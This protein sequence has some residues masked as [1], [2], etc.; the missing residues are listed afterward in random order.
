AAQEWD[1]HVEAWKLHG[2]GSR[3][4]EKAWGAGTAWPV[5]FAATGGATRHWDYEY[6]PASGGLTGVRE[7][8]TGQAVAT[9]GLDGAGRVTTQTRGGATTTLGW[10]GWDRLVEA[11]VTSAGGTV[12]AGYEYDGQGLRR[13]AQVTQTPPTGPPVVTAR[14]WTWGGED[15]AKKKCGRTSR[16]GCADEQSKPRSSRGQRGLI[17]LVD[18]L[19]PAAHNTRVRDE[20]AAITRWKKGH[21]AAARR[22]LQLLREEGPNPAQAVAEAGSAL[23]VLESEGSWP[24]PRDPVSQLAVEQVRRRWALIERRARQLRTR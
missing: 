8:A 17:D 16:L 22:Q 3:A 19:C 7:R 6:Q 13:R 18:R 1:G 21:E 12:E 24:G 23:N 14:E 9:Y 4:E 2:D 11:T 15:G 20:A 5:D 10:D